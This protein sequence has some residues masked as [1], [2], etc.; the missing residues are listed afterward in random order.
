M[1]RR[2]AR[3]TRDRFSNPPSSAR[4][5]AASTTAALLSPALGTRLLDPLQGGVFKA[6]GVLQPV[7]YQP[8]HADVGEPYQR[9]RDGERCPPEQTDEQQRSRQRIGMEG[10]VN[11][12]SNPRPRQITQHR[13]IRN[14]QEQRE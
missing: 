11:D 10:V 8:V 4:M 14:Q 6:R 2:P 5:P 13:K 12:R 1:P 3:S 7:A 9:H